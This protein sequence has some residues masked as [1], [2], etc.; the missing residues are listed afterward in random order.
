M[1]NQVI[2]SLLYP[3]I[4]HSHSLEAQLEEYTDVIG[5]TISQPDIAPRGNIVSA[6]GIRKQ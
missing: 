4:F 2:K 5:S 1:R 6:D 3:Y